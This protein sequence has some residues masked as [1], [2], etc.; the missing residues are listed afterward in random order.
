[1]LGLAASTADRKSTRLNSSH[2]Q[3]S[4]AVFCLKKKNLRCPLCASRDILSVGSEEWAKQAHRLPRAGRK[5]AHSFSREVEGDFEGR[6][7]HPSSQGQRCVPDVR[8]ERTSRQTNGRLY[9]L[10]T[11]STFLATAQSYGSG[12]DLHFHQ[13]PRLDGGLCRRGDQKFCAVGQRR[14]RGNHP[15]LE[16]SSGVQPGRGVALYLVH[17]RQ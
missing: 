3:I 17:C 13:R 7:A 15:D 1:M 10:S 16:L 14:R 12:R 6:K 9:H 4:Y 8:C 5:G 11:A 2:D